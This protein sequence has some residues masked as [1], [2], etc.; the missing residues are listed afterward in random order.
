[1]IVECVKACGRRIHP[2]FPPSLSQW[3]NEIY[4]NGQGEKIYINFWP[5]FFH[6]GENLLTPGE[7]LNVP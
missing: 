2:S 4:N 7:N 1:M 6:H 5:V 3:P